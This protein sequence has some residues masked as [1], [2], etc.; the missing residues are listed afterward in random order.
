MVEASRARHREEV[1]AYRGSIDFGVMVILVACS[2]GLYEQT[3]VV[4][5]FPCIQHVLYCI[6]RTLESEFL[7]SSCR[8]QRL[9]FWARLRLH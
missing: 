9:P 5:F 7:R 8:A 1:V 6:G 3:V 2:Y 4:R